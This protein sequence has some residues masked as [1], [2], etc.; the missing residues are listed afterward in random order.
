MSGP[1]RKS[2]FLPAGAS[3]LMHSL[4]LIAIVIWSGQGVLAQ[5]P[6][7]SATLNDPSSATSTPSKG[8]GVNSN[9][10]SSPA[11]TS[12]ISVPL[13]TQSVPYLVKVP[14]A[15]ATS[16]G[17]RDTYFTGCSDS[18]SVGYVSALSRVNI[19][20]VYSQIDRYAPDSAMGVGYPFSA[21]TL[22]VVGIGTV[23]NE[24][25]AFNSYTDSMGA[26]TGLLSESL[27]FAHSAILA[28]IF[29]HR[30]QVPYKYRLASLLCPSLATTPTSAIASIQRRM[31]HSIPMSTPPVVSMVREPSHLALTYLSIRHT[32]QEH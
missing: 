15:I 17:Q 16:N 12:V 31:T 25:Y 14:Q 28:L 4:L 19:S 20:T 21:G 8:N 22:R 13:S 18:T 7:T 27:K 11:S 1:K 3:L 29:P 26:T 23:G 32:K 6:A 10:T 2:S 9:S 24:S 30:F 5:Q